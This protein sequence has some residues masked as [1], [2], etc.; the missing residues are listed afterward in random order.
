MFQFETIIPDIPFLLVGVPLTI[1]LT[2]ASFLLGTTIALPMAVIR[3]ARTPVLHQVTVGWIEFF[4]TTPPLVHI[5]WPY[6]VFPIVF[7]INISA[8]TV[9]IM[10]L[11]ANT[12]AQ[13]AEIFRAGLQ[14][15]PKGQREAATVLGLSPVQRLWYVTLPQA[16]RLIMAPSANTLV[17]LLKDS[18]LAAIIA[19]P[20]LMN[21]GQLLSTD[22]FRPIEV[23]TLV[24]ILYFVLT[25]PLALVAAA[26]ERRSRAAF[27]TF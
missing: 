10:A 6:Y 24:A 2:L 20:E 26:L 27:R 14:A 21:R 23:L 15:V 12:S 8:V 3:I 5:F 11:A 9:V 19:V 13:M 1:G 16:V 4:R 17:S 7:G 22:T 18:S 25:Y